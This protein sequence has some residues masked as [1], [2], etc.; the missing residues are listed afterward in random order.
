MRRLRRR[1]RH[2]VAAVIG[3]GSAC[4]HTSAPPEAPVCVVV[5]VEEPQPEDVPVRAEVQPLE[6]ASPLVELKVAGYG[7]AVVSL[8]LGAT[9]RRPLLVAAHGVGDSPEW[10]CRFWRSIIEDRAF[11]LCPRGHRLESS[12]PPDEAGYFY[13]SYGDLGSEIEGA[14][15]ALMARFRRYVDPASPIFAG[16]SQGAVMGALLLPHH[17]A[18]F[19][20]AVLIEGGGGAFSEWNR[21]AARRFRQRGGARVLFA[22]GRAECASI[23]GQSEGCLQREG[24]EAQ[25]VHAMGAGH[26]YGGDVGEEIARSF[27][28]L[29]EGDERFAPGGRRP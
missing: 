28:W 23:A 18:R 11:V 27:A 22:C 4:V 13:P 6:A 19:A 10:Q 3:L 14:M 2:C 24:L 29:I 5:P 26:T 7:D 1:V 12:G 17:P 15:T 9:S 21:A 25:V 20:R 8:P 16:F